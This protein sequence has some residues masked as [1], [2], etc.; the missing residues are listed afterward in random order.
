MSEATGRLGLPL[1]VAGQGQ[2]DITHNEAI[3]ALDCAV[4]A[5]AARRDLAEPPGSAAPGACW[6][7]PPGAVGAWA[8]QEGRL[9]CWTD[10]GWRFVALADGMTVYVVSDRVTLRREGS[11]WTAV[12]PVGAPAPAVA[13]AVGGSVVD[14]EAR[15]ALGQLLER[16]RALGLVAV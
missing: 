12:A 7:V 13:D 11:G 16:L 6:L 5:V 2:K 1:L 8:G 4:G 15:A 10:G 14:V 3:L 9:A